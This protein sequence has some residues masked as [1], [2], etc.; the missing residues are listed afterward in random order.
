MPSIRRAVVAAFLAVLLMTPLSPA[1]AVPAHQ[2]TISGDEVYFT[3]T[4][5]VFAGLAA[6]DL[7]GSWLADVRH[8]PLSPSA[9][10]TGGSFYL[11]TANEQGPALIAG[12]FT[13]GSVV[14]QSG[15]S[16]CVNQTYSVDGTLGDVGPVGNDMTGSGTFS[17]VLTHYRAL[18][19]GRCVSYRA[20]VVGTV[21]LSF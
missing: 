14:Q 3:S 10:I 2:D 15:F 1:A 17:A 18:V 9:D 6:G 11:W 20:T 7:P 21:S 8:T 5:G 4:Q 19:F 16:G 12:S 13:G